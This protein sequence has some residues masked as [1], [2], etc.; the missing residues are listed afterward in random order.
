[1][2]LNHPCALIFCGDTAPS[3]LLIHRDITM[4]FFYPNRD[5]CTWLKFYILS[6]F[7]ADYVTVIRNE[8]PV[9]FLNIIF[10]ILPETPGLWVP[11][12]HSC[13]EAR[14]DLIISLVASVYDLYRELFLPVCTYLFF[15]ET[16][17]VLPAFLCVLSSSYSTRKFINSPLNSLNYL[18]WRGLVNISAQIPSTGNCFISRS[19]CD[20]LSVTHKYLVLRCLV[21]LELENL[22]FF[23]SGWHY[24]CPLEVCCTKSYTP[25]RLWSISTIVFWTWHHLRQLAR[26][27]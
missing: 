5:W 7:R 25:T 11:P 6:D 20:T 24:F 15:L 12:T 21:Y 4:I 3:A 16:T 9:I 1:M 22:P 18:P 8:T 17:V 2:W 19:P 23:L 10:Q 14:G 13:G 27:L 26:S